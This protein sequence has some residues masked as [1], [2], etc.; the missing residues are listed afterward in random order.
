MTSARIGYALENG[1][2]ISSYHHYDGYPQW[3]GTILS[4]FFS[5]PADARILIEG[6]DM[7]CCFSDTDFE[8]CLILDDTKRPSRLWRPLYNSQKGVADC[9]PITHQGIN[10]F[11][12]YCGFGKGVHIHKERLE[13]AYLYS[14]EAWTCYDIF[15]GTTLDAPFNRS[16]ADAVDKVMR[17]LDLFKRIFGQ[18]IWEKQLEYVR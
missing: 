2:V 12:R 9:E 6:G 3:L 8:G 16:K 10:D 13:Y 1:S 15:N 5:T 4:S 14:G 7:Q 18:L 11:L 17:D